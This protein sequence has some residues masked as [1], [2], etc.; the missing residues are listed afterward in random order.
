MI[1]CLAGTGLYLAAS[2]VVSKHTIDL[3]FIDVPIPRFTDFYWRGQTVYD[4][5]F[6]DLGKFL[7]WMVMVVAGFTYINLVNLTNLRRNPF[8]DNH[9]SPSS[10]YK[11]VGLVAPALFV[12]SMNINIRGKEDLVTRFANVRHYNTTLGEH[13]D[14]L[15]AENNEMTMLASSFEHNFARNYDL[16]GLPYSDQQVH[17]Y[18]LHIWAL[19]LFFG[20]QFQHIDNGI[21]E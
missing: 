20:L 1:W 9:M 14:K 4:S 11:T 12:L 10:F 19:A 5:E 2:S 18:N 8:L 6:L 21:L 17:D 13:Y 3:K 16:N 7:Y 15:A